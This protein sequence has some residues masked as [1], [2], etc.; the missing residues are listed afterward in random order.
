M[1]AK[2][3]DSPTMV[4][5]EQERSPRMGWPSV[6][7]RQQA[8]A[9]LCDVDARSC[10]IRRGSAG[11]PTH[12]FAALIFSTSVR[13]DAS[14]AGRPGRACRA[15]APIVDGTTHDASVRPVS[16]WTKTRDCRQFRQA[17]ASRIQKSRSRARRRGRLTER[18]RVDQLLTK[19][20][21]LKSTR[22]GDPSRSSR[23]YGA[24]QQ[25]PSA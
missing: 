18:F 3:I 7:L 19:R 25:P 14:V 24:R 13:R 5:E 17:L 22:L 16:G 1:I 23:L 11:L 15:R 9:W 4:R 12:G 2:W 8:R 21:V 6:A 10:A 20:H